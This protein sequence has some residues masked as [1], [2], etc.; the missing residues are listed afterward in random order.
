MPPTG[1]DE[2]VIRYT[3]KPAASKTP[4]GNKWE[5]TMV[6]GPGSKIYKLI[7]SPHSSPSLTLRAAMDIFNEPVNARSLR[8]PRGAGACLVML[9]KSLSPDG[10]LAEALVGVQP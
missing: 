7:K 4:T 3:Y 10:E 2:L 1:R 5:T 8:P 9:A 6:A